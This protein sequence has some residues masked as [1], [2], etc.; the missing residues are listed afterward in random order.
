MILLHSAAQWTVRIVVLAG[1]GLAAVWSFRVAVADYYGSSGTVEGAER[2][3]AWTPDQSLNYVRLSILTADT[4]R[5][6]AKQALERAVAWNPTDARS[7]IDLALRWELEG[8]LPR[9]ERCLL[10]AADVDSQYLPRW[11]LAN[12]YYRRNDKDRFWL[13]AKKASEM[14]YSD[15][16]PLF[17]L[18]DDIADGGNL[19]DRLDMHTP[20]LRASY[21]NY[22]VAKGRK[23]LI[24]P[25]AL[26][27]LPDHRPA[28]VPILLSA[29]D[30]LLRLDRVDDAV[31]VWNSLSAYN[32]IPH[33]PLHPDVDAAVVNDEFSTPPSSRGFD[34]IL[35]DILG[36]AASKEE[37]AGGLRLTF[38][39]SQPES[40]RVLSQLIPVKEDSR[41]AADYR[42]ATSG[43]T[44]PSGLAWSAEFPDLKDSAPISAEIA[45]QAEQGTRSFSFD[46]PPGCHLV[47]LG[48]AYRRAVG[49]TRIEGRLV[50]RQVHLRRVGPGGSHS[51]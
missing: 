7:W 38:S 51:S 13:W 18:C 37:E 19:L 47:R 44:D 21:L 2:A 15:P 3:I 49:T 17:R 22:V 5:A 26:H 25:V 45:A 50:L 23:E 11:S 41:Y 48:V 16:A 28:D 8:D 46:T 27:L 43:I 35:P 42:Y 14:L 24:Y 40:C 30:H 33:P 1:L 10:H 6:R 4:D 36:V 12:F 39:G 9:A 29:C 32:E 31:A 34:W 20:D